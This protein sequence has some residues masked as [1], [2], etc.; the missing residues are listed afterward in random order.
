M[1]PDTVT[2]PAV[3][4][5]APAA[6]EQVVETPAV[7]ETEAPEAPQV[8]VT[9]EGPTVAELQAALAA[10]K[11][12]TAR[13]VAAEQTARA[14]RAEL[15]TQLGT[16]TAD[17]EAREAERVANLSLAEK[18]AEET[19]KRE[20]AEQAAASVQSQWAEF[21]TLSDL[22]R[23]GFLSGL[24][25]DA[26][27]AQLETLK[28]LT[29]LPFVLDEGTFSLA[30]FSERFGSMKPA[31]PTVLVA[32]PVAAPVVVDLG[33]TG[34]PPGDAKVSRKTELQSQIAEATKRGDRMAVLSLRGQLAAL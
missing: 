28:A 26:K 2:T 11:A 33:G 27:T 19:A 20:A 23:G 22:E 12:K 31:A 14:K 13:A 21:R 15:E 5:E 34:T 16:F 4:Q 10:E 17:A 1:M 6:P 29:S 24:E 25:G 18:L 9:P 8:E 3:A 30:K 32:E 7:T